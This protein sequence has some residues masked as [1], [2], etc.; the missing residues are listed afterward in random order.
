MKMKWKKLLALVLAVALVIGTGVFA[1]DYNL[2]ATEGDEQQ[3][4]QATVVEQEEIDLSGSG[5]ETE[6]PSEET[7]EPQEDGLQEETEIEEASEEPEESEDEELPEG[8]TTE[9]G[10]TAAEEPEE[11]EEPETVSYPARTIAAVSED[12]AVVMV[13]APEGALP[14]GAYVQVTV[15]DGFFK[16]IRFRNAIREVIE[17][18]KDI[19]EMKAL[20]I[21]ICDSEG[22]EVQPAKP[23]H[24]TIQN[25]G[26]SGEGCA[27]VFHIS[28]DNEAES[29]G[30]SAD[31]GNVT[32]SAE[33]FSPYVTVTY[34][35]SS[36]VTVSEDTTIYSNKGETVTVILADPSFKW[37]GE[38]GNGS[39]IKVEKGSS[40]GEY[41]VTR[42]NE[43]GTEHVIFGKEKEKHVIFG[44]EKEKIKVTFK[45]GSENDPSITVAPKDIE[46][47]SLDGSSQLTPVVSGLEDGTQY[48]ITWSS[49]DRN[50]ADVFDGT[51]RPVGEGKATI[52]ATLT[53]YEYRN[54]NESEI[55]T[56]TDSAQVSV[57]LGVQSLY[58]YAL[59]PG[60]DEKGNADSTWYGLGIT[61]I[62]APDPSGFGYGVCNISYTEISVKKTLYPDIKFKGITYKYAAQESEY[63]DR[64]G[65]YTLQPG[66]I[67]VADGANAG[68]NK[69]N[70]P[71]VQSGTKTY[72]LDYVMRINEAGYHNV[73]FMVMEPGCSEYTSVT[74]FARRVKDET[75]EHDVEPESLH[76]RTYNGITYTF[77]GWYEDSACSIPANF[78]GTVRSDRTYYGKYV[79]SQQKYQIKY[80]YD[81][82]EDE[83][84]RVEKTAAVGDVI[85][86]YEDKSAEGYSLSGDTAP[87]TVS[88]D[89]EMNVICVFYTRDTVQCTVN[90]VLKGTASP[91]QESVP[92]NDRKYG[93]EVTVT[94]P[95]IEGYTLADDRKKS[96]TLSDT[97]RTVTFEYC[98]NITVKADDVSKVY[99]DSDPEFTASFTAGGLVN[100][101]DSLE[102]TIS[103]EEGENA[104]SRTVTPSGETVQGYYMVTY[105]SGELTITKRPVTLT[106]ASD[107]K[108][109]DGT[110]LANHTVTEGGRGFAAGEG[111]RY[112]VTGSVTD[113]ADSAQNNNT[114]T[115]TLNDGTSEDNY[116]ITSVYGT[117]TIT[118]VTNQVTVKIN[119]KNSSSKY[120]GRVHKADGYD[121][122]SVNNNLYSEG[123]VKLTETAHAERTDAGTS[124]MGLGS[125]SFENTS[126]NFSNVVFEV[127]D[128]SVTVEKRNVTLTSADATKTFDK[129]PLVNNSVTAGGDGFAAG[130]G[131]KYSVTGSQT[132]AGYSANEFTYELNS[133][134]KAENYNITV[135]YGTL[136]VNAYNEKVTVT[137]LENSAEYV[138]DGKVHTA[139]GYTVKSIS[140]DRYTGDDFEYTGNSAS[141]SAKDAGEYNLNIAA[142]DF[143]NKNDSFE[144]VEFVVEHGT[145]RIAKRELTL[146]SGTSTKVYDGKPLVNSEV[147][148]SAPGFVEGE[149]PEYIFTQSA[150]EPNGS[151]VKNTFTCRFPDGVSSDNYKLNL[152]PGKLIVTE[153]PNEIIV[154]VR[155]KTENTTYNGSLQSAVGYDVVSVTEAG[156]SITEYGRDDFNYQGSAR[157]EGTDAGTYYMGLSADNFKNSNSY[158]KNVKFIVLSDGWI[159][160]D[161]KQ[162]T[163]TSDS[164]VKEY[165]GTEL[166]AENITGTEDFIGNDGVNITFA[167]KSRLTD[168]GT[169]ANEF[170][171]TFNSNTES[172]NYKVTT[173]FGTLKITPV[174]KA[175]TI[176]ISGYQKETEYN[177]SE[178]A[179]V[180]YYV[181]NAEN[182]AP[183][184]PSDIIWSGS[185]EAKGTDA[186]TY[187]MKLNKSQFSSSDNFTNV[188]FV[189]EE[190]GWIKINPAQITL[191]SAS[192]EKE[193]DG[194]PLTAEKVTV[195]SGSFAAGEGIDNYSVSGSRTVK[196]TGKNTFEYTLLDGTD[197]ANYII[198]KEEGTLKV[199]DREKK[200]EITVRPNSN[201]AVYDG[202]QHS[203]E[204]FETASYTVNGNEFTVEGLTASASGKSAGEYPVNVSGTAAVKDE[205]GNYVTDQFNVTTAAGKLVIN[206]R[207]V[208]LTSASDSKEY[209]GKPLTNSS[210]SAS[211][212]ENSGFLRGEGVTCSV[213][214][215][216]IDAG[217]TENE[218][219]Y[220]AKIGTNLENYKISKE[221]GKLKV[222]K[223]TAGITVTAASA[224][225]KYDGRPLA[226]SGFTYTDNI[227]VEGDVIE[228]EVEGTIT[229]A[230][231][232]PNKVTSYKVMRDGRDVTGNY[233]FSTPADGILT[234]T[235]R[236]VTLT[237][238]TDSKTYD[239]SPLVNRSV[240]VDGDGFAEGEGA[241]YNVTGTITEAGFTENEFTYTLLEGTKAS[242]YEISKI[243]GT[244]TVGKNGTVVVTVTENS[245]TELYDGTEKSVSGYS[246]SV[247]DPKYRESDFRFS[248]SASAAGTDAG[249][250]SM[251]LKPSDFENINSNF[252]NV[253]FNI[254]EGKLIIA[255]RKVTLISASDT[256]VY[257]GTA[258]ENDNVTAGG[259]GFAEG[260]GARYNVTGS[261][262]DAGIEVNN[263]FE[264]TLKSGTS[265][266]NYSIT[267][268]EGTLLVTPARL[269][270]VTG[271][272]QQPFNGRPLTAPGTISGFVNGETAPF[273]V[274][275]EV[276]GSRES[277][278]PVREENTYSID[279]NSEDATAD[280]NNYT[281]HASTGEL[282]ITE[283]VE[284]TLTVRYWY[285]KAGGET[286]AD[287]FVRSWK[288]GD[289]E[290]TVES[291]S[292]PGYAP[293]H[294]A[295]TVEFLGSDAEVNV[296]YTPV[297]ASEPEDPEESDE[298][299]DGEE[300]NLPVIDDENGA[301]IE[302]ENDPVIE[303]TGITDAD[304]LDIAR[305]GTQ[306]VFTA[307]TVTTD[308]SG[309]MKFTEIKDEETPLANVDIGEEPH[310]ILHWLILLAAA[311]VFIISYFSNRKLQKELD[312]MR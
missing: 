8:E 98:R 166:K 45:P 49:S 307:G 91:V 214:G 243:F 237:S 211:T 178:Q 265:E 85:S 202:K 129:E 262:T 143:R 171:C 28:E 164:A 298:T 16:E 35:N 210:V 238:A 20:D 156:R 142:A 152:V 88:E 276:T 80:F 14:Q 260:E 176:R 119:G 300:E 157:A 294:P 245:K 199:K 44:K 73:G 144:N 167:R 272:A 59:I 120:D 102:Y 273:I 259:D 284:Y 121:I 239:E 220:T 6:E 160:I 90:Y 290:F 63:A 109:Y 193:Y 106:S 170:S 310:C 213:T 182:I 34:R 195:T 162:I 277:S 7:A 27:E 198:T 113:V 251:E 159:K 69:Y 275:G 81:G 97:S 112:S 11:T 140:S 131:A 264:Y 146:E 83:S 51:V 39:I 77:S 280:R 261:V 270:V 82:V 226:D 295:I 229:D 225:K 130:E 137:I 252:E 114:F 296:V 58:H 209:D 247:T 22:N 266:D 21:T 281:V 303:E 53:Y 139:S 3:T 197:A 126:A 92:V 189:I 186:G 301:G 79:P 196:G 13:D 26:I 268:N 263:E 104:G 1:S 4:E 17:E 231:T 291:P 206:P 153:N 271:S 216:I 312:S 212:G 32:F 200:F 255:K 165:D 134:T 297:Y 127:T 37:I 233:T 25:T 115:Y 100:S 253:T 185:F 116:D 215:N 5:E 40:A 249:E 299:G 161:P 33:G 122:S 311:A 278:F 235:K 38:T 248:G 228:A 224:E 125:D 149:T 70:T 221:A 57:K 267:K 286:A 287:T 105:E 181:S 150:S 61:E 230:G 46:F 71:V 31:A 285:S 99:G 190:D 15:L 173:V 96:I 148:V 154:T 179:I 240:S 205:N 223:K 242:N 67:V 23:V 141:V 101:A 250:Y 89:P 293:D 2:K 241:S 180:G 256:K 254:V 94:A 269:D 302:K 133:N 177:G 111:A 84:R 118:P 304:N 64:T 65:Y 136:T 306:I 75:S 138:Y 55:K 56:L 110:T 183:F 207:P 54:K 43:K 135:E 201:A 103:R 257:D 279:W 155:G 282:V 232:A 30:V 208:K 72:H 66:R 47:T 187:N 95:D 12:G 236:N 258:L 42:V 174:E 62:A 274:T 86:E 308:S 191:T 292:I 194:N 145:L 107:T 289:D 74:D 227:L 108:V 168:T 48:Y 60:A 184:G 68:N 93:D 50:V 192:A 305:P 87:L 117:L 41:K 175:I 244:L 288:Y 78:D 218:F 124:Y 128:G 163:L 36:Y 222:T 217:E 246:V 147:S 10:E 204:G 283:P 123:S 52:T 76:D 234:V 309:N 18:G 19:D 188:T 172:R 203:V 158:Y 219:T 24:V 132:F 9:P 151:G 29:V 169:V